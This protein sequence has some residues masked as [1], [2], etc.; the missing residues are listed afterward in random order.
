MGPR[1]A[2]ENPLPSTWCPTCHK[3]VSRRSVQRLSK[4]I[5]GKTDLEEEN[6][7]ADLSISP[8]N[9]LPRKLQQSSGNMSPSQ[10]DVSSPSQGQSVMPAQP[11]LLP[12]PPPLPPGCQVPSPPPPMPG[13]SASSRLSPQPCSSPECNHLTCGHGGQCHPQKTPTLRMKMFHWQKLPPDAVRRTCLFVM[14]GCLVHLLGV[15]IKVLVGGGGRC[16][17]P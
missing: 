7:M 8:T 6:P 3:T 11:Q 15:Q 5:Q 14:L 2:M 16:F 12:A 4:C 17:R 13:I 9:D 10:K 1:Q